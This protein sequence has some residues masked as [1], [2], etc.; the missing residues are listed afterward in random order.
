MINRTKQVWQVGEVVKVG[1]M[2]LRVLAAVPTPGNWLPD[3][4]ALTDLTGER[5]YRFVPHNGCTRVADL[6]EAMVPA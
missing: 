1:F 6:N 3:Q 5:F 4:Y 2:R